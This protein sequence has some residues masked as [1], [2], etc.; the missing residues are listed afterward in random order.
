MMTSWLHPLHC[1][2]GMSSP[3]Q[4]TWRHIQSPSLHIGRNYID[5]SW[6]CAWGV[7]KRLFKEPD[8]PRKSAFVHPKTT[9]QQPFSQRSFY[10]ILIH[11]FKMLFN[12]QS[13]LVG[14]S[15]ISQALSAPVLESRAVAGMLIHQPISV[16]LGSSNIISS[17]R[18]FP[19]FAPRSKAFFCCLHRL[20]RKG[21][22]CHNYQEDL[23]PPDWHQC[24]RGICSIRWQM[25]NFNRA[26]L[27]TPLRRRRSRSS[28]GD[29]LLVWKYQ[30]ILILAHHAN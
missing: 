11:S 22:R 8:S 25:T 4:P 26:S 14:V 15:L 1:L 9:L 30:F 28:W 21:L 18:C 12:Y 13:L 27:D 7:S 2:F 17:Q 29:R 23:W 20:H 6:G 3:T 10:N 24:R 5:N 16:R 19:W